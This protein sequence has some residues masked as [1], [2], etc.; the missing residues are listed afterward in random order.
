MFKNIINVSL[1][2]QI[3]FFVFTSFAVRSLFKKVSFVKKIEKI[4]A[5]DF[6]KL[7]YTLVLNESSG[8][9]PTFDQ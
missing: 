3:V 9:L 1:E 7:R 5:S 8:V 4:N 2:S 6:V